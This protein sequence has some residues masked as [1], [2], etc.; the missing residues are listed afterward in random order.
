MPIIK[1]RP[2][3][4]DTDIGQDIKQKLK[5]LTKDPRYNTVSS[6]STNGLLYSNNLIP[7][8]DK[9]MNYL[10]SHPLLDPYKYIA[11]VKLVTRIR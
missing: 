11:N 8:I 9:H 2:G 6:Y 1:S 10:V 3:F 5:L 4:A 7:F